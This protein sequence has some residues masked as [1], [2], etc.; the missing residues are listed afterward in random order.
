MEQNPDYY[1]GDG[2]G[3]QVEIIEK[4]RDSSANE[5]VGAAVEADEG[6]AVA[7]VQGEEELPGKTVMGE[8]ES[9]PRVRPI[10]KDT[11]HRICSGQVRWNEAGAVLGRG[12]VFSRLVTPSS[13]HTSASTQISP[14]RHTT[15]TSFMHPGCAIAGDCCQRITGE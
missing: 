3:E 14:F 11:V 1:T 15:L 8:A 10:D 13:S 9:G 12:Y 7:H 2:D 6:A 4:N 5:D